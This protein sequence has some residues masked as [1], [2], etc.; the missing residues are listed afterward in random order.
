MCTDNS[1]SAVVG[2]DPLT[3]TKFASITPGTAAGGNTQVQFNNGGNFVRL[4]GVEFE[5]ISW[6]LDDCVSLLKV[7]SEL[8]S[9]LLIPKSYL[10]VGFSFVVIADWPARSPAP[11]LR[12]TTDPMFPLL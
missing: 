11:E 10:P 5:N 2:T 12:K 1:G 6:P 8:I 9:R 4:L 3:F 7:I